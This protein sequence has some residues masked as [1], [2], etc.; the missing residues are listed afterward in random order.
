MLKLTLD[1]NAV[2]YL[3][4]FDSSTATSVDELSAII[5]H[6]MEGNVNL[7]ITTVVSRDLERDEDDKRRVEMLRKIEMFPVIGTLFRLDASRRDPGT[8]WVPRRT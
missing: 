8:C 1:K 7:C 6:A 4:D 5:R 3:L 2:I